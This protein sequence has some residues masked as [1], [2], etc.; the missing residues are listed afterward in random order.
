MTLVGIAKKKV[1]V[2]RSSRARKAPLNFTDK[3]WQFFG[4]LPSYRVN[5]HQNAGGRH[6][7]AILGPGAGLG[8][9]SD[10]VGDKPQ[11]IQAIKKKYPGTTFIS[12]HLLNADFGGDGK[13]HKNLTV[14]TSTGNANHKKFDEPIKKALM[15]LRTAYQAMNELGIDVKAIRYGIKVDIEVTGKEWGD[16]YPNNCI[17][18]SLTCKAKVVNDD[19]ALAELVPHKNREKADAAITAVQ[20]LV[21]EA[22]AN[23]EIANLPDGE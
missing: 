13:D 16:T 1:E 9:G 22:N 4:D 8:K 14:L 21:D 12:G 7:S 6:S 20:H 5:E 23:G 10:S 19:K 3:Y 18:K 17:F 11:A 15:Q 2:R